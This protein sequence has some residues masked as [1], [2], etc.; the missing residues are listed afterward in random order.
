MKESERERE[1]KR[2]IASKV[3]IRRNGLKQHRT[4]PS[5]FVT[6]TTFELVKI[7]IKL[8]N[9]KT[10]CFLLLFHIN[11]KDNFLF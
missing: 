3:K 5:K 7:K 11:L 1:R 10:A 9:I 8:F 4:K 6:V 2:R